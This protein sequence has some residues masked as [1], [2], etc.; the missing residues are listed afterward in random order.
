[1]TLRK[2]VRPFVVIAT[3]ITISLTSLGV[4][5]IRGSAHPSHSE[6]H[7]HA[8]G[9][10]HLARGVSAGQLALHDAMR[11]LWEEHVL[12]TRLFIVSDVA[13]LPDLSATTERLLRNQVDL[14][15]A[16]K[17]FYGS[18]AGNQ[19]T[20][21]LRQHILQAADILNAAKTGNADALASA[22]AAWY[23]NAQ[24]IAAFLHSLN[25]G[26]WPLDALQMMMR[27][28]LDLTL[29]EAVDQL[30]GNFAQSVAD[31]DNVEAEILTMADTLSNGIIAQFG[32]HL[33]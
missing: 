22:K 18:E 19:L 4:A 25:P 26:Q 6:H 5:A 3:V 24:Q 1:M 28:H 27:E 9:E 15:D 13:N 29:T 10:S 16:F 17:P 2:M 32:P 14:G 23:A 7:G 33:G 20:M 11:K 30:S 31:F 21:L 8:A 12:W